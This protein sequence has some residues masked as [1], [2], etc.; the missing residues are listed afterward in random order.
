MTKRL[1][2]LFL[3]FITVCSLAGPAVS[4]AV[5]VGDVSASD[6]VSGGDVSGSE[7]SG[8]DV[9]GGDVQPEGD[10]Y[11]TPAPMRDISAAELVQDMKVG[12]NLGKSLDS[13][14]SDAGYDDYYNANA[15]QMIVTYQ[16]GTDNILNVSVPTTFKS[17]NTCIISWDTNMIVDSEPRSLLGSIGFQIWNFA[18][19]EPTE[20]TIKVTRAE[21]YKKTTRK[22]YVLDELMGEHTLT[23]SR[24]GTVALN[25]TKFPKDLSH[26]Q[27][28]QNGALTIAVELVDYPQRSYTK[29][30]YFEALWN[31]PLT[32]RSMITEIKRSGFNA[33]R[34]PITYF[35]HTNS[36]NIVDESWLD[37]VAEVV[38]YVVDQDMYC[39]IDMH[40]DGSTSGWLRVNTD[41]SEEVLKKYEDI[42][43]QVA[44][45]FKNY[46][47]RLLFEGYSE[48]TN[49]DEVWGYPGEEDIDWVN[50][51]AQLFVDTVRKTG[52]N[53]TQRFLLVSPYAASHEQ[54]IIDGFKLP[55]D[56][57]QD[58]LIVSIHAYTPADFS[59]S[60]EA[61]DEVTAWGSDYN[62]SVIDEL[63]Q[64]LDSRFVSRGTPVLIT[65]FGSVSKNATGVMDEPDPVSDSDAET[66]EP[67]AGAGGSSGTSAVQ[68][69]D[70]GEDDEEAIPPNTPDRVAHARYYV[71]K[72][73]E[74]GISCFWWDSGDLLD[75]D[76]ST[77]V[78][79]EI[80]DA[81]VNTVSTHIN[82]ATVA[83]IEPQ[84]ATGE[85]VMP[86]VSL[87]IEAQ[88][89]SGTSVV[90]L[91][92]GV[93]YTVSYAGN[94][95]P[96]S[97]VVVISGIG[98][99]TGLITTGFELMEPPSQRSFMGALS[100]TGNS[101]SDLLVW[102]F[103]LPII[104]GLGVVAWM[105]L[106]ERKRLELVRAGVAKA[107]E[108]AKRETEE[109]YD[110][111]DEY[112]YDDDDD[113]W[114][115]EDGDGEENFDD[116]F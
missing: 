108:E 49:K 37:R 38:D 74:Y 15:Y 13:W 77:W 59:W 18:V 7:V 112:E 87:S 9:S 110:A 60:Y 111:D 97:A 55:T 48:L 65:E 52:G 5:S 83:P 50:N 68:E 78:Y 116:D 103:S 29:E 2:A 61:E 12:W 72:A 35:N 80:V 46:G 85:G 102:A 86:P 4:A 56:S 96:G 34:V 79:P 58:R 14:S 101:L 39:I 24:Y 75:R 88:G 51:L 57:A 47:D 21:L 19:D 99:Y 20:I 105:Q 11:A 76:S 27:G 113:D 100:V 89:V 36:E 90:K 16:D 64:R 66:P 23:I 3:A 114:D 92:E 94:V 98:D 53:N 28:V 67:P 91:T 30:Q 54:E 95:E 25:T 1:A 42:W 63:F 82:K 115:G 69:N 109:Y 26:T 104:V 45:R 40:N 84:Y 22:K 43:T 44:E 93:D 41:K 8:G 71:G 62:K 32:T 33:V 17:D 31:N 70:D 73:R 106:K 81:M 107:T 10:R 6:A